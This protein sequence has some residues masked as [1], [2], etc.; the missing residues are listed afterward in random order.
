M[1]IEKKNV[2]RRIWFSCFNFINH[3]WG[4]IAQFPKQVCFIN[5]TNPPQNDEF[6][7]MFGRFHAAEERRIYSVFF[8]LS[9][10]HRNKPY[11]THKT[12]IRRHFTFAFII[13]LSMWLI[14]VKG[15]Y[16]IYLHFSLYPRETSEILSFYFVCWFLFIYYFNAFFFCTH[17]HEWRKR[18]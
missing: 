7:I 3:H 5:N 16:N 14:R 2:Y 15:S 11:L 4:K 1:C 9:P 13:L 8:P 12:K 10:G 6:R 17:C 18:N